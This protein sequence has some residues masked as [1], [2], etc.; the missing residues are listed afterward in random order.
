MVK[1]KIVSIFFSLLMASLIVS[2]GNKGIEIENANT[3]VKNAGKMAAG[4]SK[5]QKID[6]NYNL[7]SCR[8]MLTDDEK[9]NIMEAY[10]FEKTDDFI[11]NSDLRNQL[12]DDLITSFSNLATTYVDKIYDVNAISV[13]ANKEEYMSEMDKVFSD[14]CIVGT[15]GNTFKEEWTQ[16]VIDSGVIMDARF[17]TGKGYVYADDKE[18][19][20]R[21]IL[22]LKVE[23]A[24]DI[25][26]IQKYLPADVEVGQEY[27]FVYDIGFV[28]LGEEEDEDI[29]LD[30]GKIDY[31][32][33]LGAY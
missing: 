30:N 20:V 25:T 23:S 3:N 14:N 21:G 6:V 16:A 17:S 4:N 32:L 26:K 31:I 7:N 9:V 19:Y 13:V 24:E 33:A 2:C 29:P 8:K 5:D 28:A 1:K 11:S 10:E 27:N 18:V 12:G 15:D 22:N